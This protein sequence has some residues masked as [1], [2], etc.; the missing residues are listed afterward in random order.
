MQIT[1]AD[2]QISS[3]GQQYNDF[4]LFSRNVPLMERMPISWIIQHV[5]QLFLEYV[6]QAC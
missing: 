6:L 4:V 5:T 2:I 3:R 1:P